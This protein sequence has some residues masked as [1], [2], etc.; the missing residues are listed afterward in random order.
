MDDQV[1]RHKIALLRDHGWIAAANAAKDEYEIS[2]SWSR[3][4]HAAR[5]VV[6]QANVPP[7]DMEWF[8]KNIQS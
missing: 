3:A 5:L 7:G 2:R 4:L 6:Q 8:E 1:A